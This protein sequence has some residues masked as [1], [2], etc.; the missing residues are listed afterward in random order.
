MPGTCENW[1]SLVN[2]CVYSARQTREIYQVLPYS[3]DFKAPAELWNPLRK[4][5]LS[6]CSFIPNKGPVKLW[7]DRKLK[8]NLYVGS[9]NIF[10]FF[11]LASLRRDVHDMRRLACVTTAADIMLAPLWIWRY[12]TQLQ[13]RYCTKSG[14]ASSRM[15]HVALAAITGTPIMV[16]YL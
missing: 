2:S 6:K 7:N 13:S 12:I 5:V 9:V 14:G 15:E 3:V 11:T 1:L 16:A 4:T 8:S 10:L